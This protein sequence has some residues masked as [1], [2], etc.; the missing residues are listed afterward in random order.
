MSITTVYVVTAAVLDGYGDI[1]VR[2]RQQGNSINPAGLAHDF[3]GSQYDGTFDIIQQ[4]FFKFELDIP[5]DATLLGLRF[6]TGSG[7]ESSVG[8]IDIYGGFLKRQ[9]NSKPWESAAACKIWEIE[10]DVPLANFINVNGGNITNDAV[11]FGGSPGFPNT[12]MP[13]AGIPDEWSFGEGTFDGE[14]NADV[15]GLLAQLQ[16]YLDDDDN[17]ATRGDTST[18]DIAVMLTF[19]REVVGD[20][21]EFQ[22]LPMTDEPYF[23]QKRPRLEI[24]YEPL[25]DAKRVIGEPGIRPAVSGAA[26]VQGAVSGAAS[27]QGAV[28]GSV[29]ARDAVSGSVRACDAVTGSGRIR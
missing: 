28:S 11:F 26:S 8:P 21:N 23:P 7:T 10:N 6:Y 16:A 4:G 19:L 17:K 13:R 3:I 1:C 12:S 5:E 22:Y 2:Q 29:R 14:T 20:R 27:V 9:E 15:V 25:P 18:G 24:E